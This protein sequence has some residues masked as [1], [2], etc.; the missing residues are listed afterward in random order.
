MK[1]Y[2]MASVCAAIALC[3]CC[4]NTPQIKTVLVDKPI[5][6]APQPPTVPQCTDYTTALSQSDVTDPGKVVQAYVLDLTCYKSNDRTF[7]M[8][9]EQYKKIADQTPTITKTLDEVSSDGKH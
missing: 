3:G 6:Y 4:T 5:P 8:I 9:L 2:T 1:S 7:R